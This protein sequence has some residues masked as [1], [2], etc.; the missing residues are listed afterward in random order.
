MPCGVVVAGVDRVMR[1]K[2]IIR[3]MRGSMAI[4][5]SY[6]EGDVYGYYEYYGVKQS[7]LFSVL[8][9]LY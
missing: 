3:I 7:D 2:Y 1:N 4:Y 6:T 8:I 5:G 9:E